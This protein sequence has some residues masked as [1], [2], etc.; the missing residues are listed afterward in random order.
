MT[1]AGN[2]SIWARLH[3]TREGERVKGKD[4]GREEE[5]GRRGERL[6]RK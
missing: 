3:D 2:A 1:D 6:G 4:K 5:E